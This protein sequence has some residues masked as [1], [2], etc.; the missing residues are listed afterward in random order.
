[1]CE[2]EKQLLSS[3]GKCLGE[4][5]RLSEEYR[6]RVERFFPL[7]DDKNSERTFEAIKGI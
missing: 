3:L 1:M 6:P 4:D 7:R 2:S 5:A